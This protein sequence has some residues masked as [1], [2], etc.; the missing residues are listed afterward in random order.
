MG[1]APSLV[2]IDSALSE[3]PSG[4]ITDPNLTVTSIDDIAIDINDFKNVGRRQYRVSA[5]SE[6]EYGKYEVKASEYNRDKF[7]IIE[8]SLNLNRPTLPIPPQQPM[9]IPLPPK[10]P[11]IKD[12]TSR[13]V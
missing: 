11:I 12:I 6:T 8:K 3:A 13:N 4:E 10:D 7:D 9:D 5:V 2:E 1:S